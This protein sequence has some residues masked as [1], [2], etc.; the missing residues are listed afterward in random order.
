M[1]SN[2][3]IVV[4]NEEM[5]NLDM[6]SKTAELCT[7][8]DYAVSVIIPTYKREVEFL[9]RAVM[10]VLNQSYKD[11]EVIVV[12]DSPDSFSRRNDISAYM[13][14]VMNDH[15]NV[16]YIQNERNIGGALARNRGIDIARGR[17]ISFLDDDDEYMPEKVEKQVNFMEAYK[18]DMSFSNMIMYNN[19][20]VVVD[21]REYGDIKSLDACSLLKYH[22]MYHL[23]GTPTFMYKTEKLREIGGFDDAKMGQEFFLML[24]SIEK[25]LKIGYQ[26]DCDVIVYK[27]AGEAISQGK[28]KIVG[29]K[30]L[31]KYK[32]RYFSSLSRRERRFIRFRHFAV[33]VVAYKR[34]AMYIRMLV[35]GTTAFIVSP[36]DFVRQVIK[37][38][39][40]VVSSNIK[41]VQ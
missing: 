1:K 3:I 39:C 29:E 8:Y 24:K 37:F 33:M 35:A 27:H 40:K 13:Q 30:N 17:Y 4:R 26:N 32:Q 7:E 22:L 15:E 41:R 2:P 28:N 14:K 9:A 6:E 34:N 38:V 21:K 19:E 31:Y 23:T 12:D 18:Y 10:S 11:I 25:G 16:I 36:I 5:M 20:G